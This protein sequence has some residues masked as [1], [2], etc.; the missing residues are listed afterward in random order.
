MI[1]LSC[2][3]VRGVSKEGVRKAKIGLARA[4]L[5]R[6]EKVKIHA[7]LDYATCNIKLLTKA[8]QEGSVY[9]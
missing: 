3:C 2:D 4:T 6:R 5:C 7:L 1:L 9:G 8:M